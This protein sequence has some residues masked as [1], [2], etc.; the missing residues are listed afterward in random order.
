MAFFDA[1]VVRPEFLTIYGSLTN[2]Q[3]VDALITNTGVVFT[4]SERDAL[5]NG[6]NSATETRATVLRKIAE[7]DSFRQAQFNRAFV[8]IQ[9]VG[10]LRRSPTDPPDNNLDGFNFWLNKLNQFNGNFVDAEMVKAF[11]L[12]AEY[13]QRFGP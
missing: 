1:F 3:Y 12:S 8:Y 10:Y 2:D 4:A 11:I 7:K 13:R 5:V 9:Y 6:L